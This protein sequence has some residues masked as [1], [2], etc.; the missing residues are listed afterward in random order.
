[1]VT[2]RPI[3][4]GE[5]DRVVRDLWTRFEAEIADLDGYDPTTG[6]TL[7][8]V[9]DARRERVDRSDAATLVAVP[10]DGDDGD[11]V[12]G[13]PVGFVGV[14]LVGPS[15]VADGPETV[16][17][18]LYVVPERRREGIGSDLLGAAEDWG[19]ERDCVV[20]RV[21]VSPDNEAAL[22]TYRER[23]Y[24]ETPHGLVRILR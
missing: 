21:S 5:V 23:G 19:R 2:I 14:E 17:D 15:P 11:G 24:A 13:G 16:V 9:V 1:M 3:R 12:F 4:P 7:S 8:T 18:E 20:V 10:A 22:A 6:G